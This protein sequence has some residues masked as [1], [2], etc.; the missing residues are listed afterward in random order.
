[1]INYRETRPAAMDSGIDCRTC[2][3][4]MEWITIMENGDKIGVCAC[5]WTSWVTDNGVAFRSSTEVVSVRKNKIVE[6]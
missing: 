6:R 4:R 2:G 1:M 5:P 3:E